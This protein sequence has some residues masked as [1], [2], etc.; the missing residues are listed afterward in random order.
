M[1]GDQELPNRKESSKLVKP[2]QISNE[3]LELV[4]EISPV[5][6]GGNTFEVVNIGAKPVDDGED[7]CL[8]LHLFLDLTHDKNPQVRKKALRELCPCH[9][10]VFNLWRGN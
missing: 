6:N 5:Q 1:I 9:V 3:K 10:K 4:S 2:I 8:S 7:E